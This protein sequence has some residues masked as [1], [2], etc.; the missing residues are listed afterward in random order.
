MVTYQVD[1]EIKTLKDV[2]VCE[3]HGFVNLGTGGKR[4][5]WKEQLKSGKEMLTL[6]DLRNAK[7]YTEWGY[8][9]IRDMFESW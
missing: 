3:F 7:Y 8:T 5:E 1:D 4:R 6:L 9:G 2:V